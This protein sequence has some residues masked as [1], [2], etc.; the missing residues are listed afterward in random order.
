MG[1]VFARFVLM[2]SPL[3]N[4]ILLCRCVQTDG[5]VLWRAR[6]LLFC[7]NSGNKRLKIDGDIDIRT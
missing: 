1:V 4:L 7:R 3:L 5:A 6:L 2:V